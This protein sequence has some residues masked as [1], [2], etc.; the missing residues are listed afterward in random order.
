ML[1]R[2]A[3]QLLAEANAEI[4]TVTAH[5]QTYKARAVV[6]AMGAAARYLDISRR[7]LIYRMEKHGLAKVESETAENSN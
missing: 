4:K 3:K 6:L 7:T 1:K 5:G 2:G